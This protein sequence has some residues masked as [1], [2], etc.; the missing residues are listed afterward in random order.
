M[1]DPAPSRES[2][3]KALRRGGVRDGGIIPGVSLEIQ[4]TIF[5]LLGSSGKGF[6][7]EEVGGGGCHVRLCALRASKNRERTIACSP[8][9]FGERGGVDGGLLF[10]V[11]S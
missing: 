4:R 7:I 5:T 8:S 2:L 10:V 1:P 3:R 6:I 9:L 11:F